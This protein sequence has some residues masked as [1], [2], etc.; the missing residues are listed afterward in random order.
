MSLNKNAFS[1][2]TVQVG[3]GFAGAAQ[4]VDV[5]PGDYTALPEGTNLA[6]LYGIYSKHSV[7]AADQAASR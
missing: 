4:A 6:L 7:K 2:S 5:D 1:K 3:F